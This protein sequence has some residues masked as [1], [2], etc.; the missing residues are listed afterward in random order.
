MVYEIKVFLISEPW[1]QTLASKKDFFLNYSNMKVNRKF[2]PAPILNCVVDAL[3]IPLS[4]K[5]LFEKA[6]NCVD[7][8]LS[9]MQGSFRKLEID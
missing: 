4:S 8:E 6:S 1:K 5:D 3:K 2:Y 7:E 9:G